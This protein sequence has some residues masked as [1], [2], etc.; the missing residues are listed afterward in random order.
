M[1]TQTQKDSTPSHRVVPRYFEMWNTGDVSVAAEVLSPDWADHAHPEVRAPGD[2]QHAVAQTRAARPGLRFHV[3]A[4][5]GAD[6][7]VSV[8]GGVG[9]ES[10]PGEFD[11]RLIWLVRLLDGRMVEMW[12]YRLTNS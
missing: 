8:V 6:D 10:R 2:V 9:H 1:P 12:T 4:V 3:E 7:L 11:S 5:L